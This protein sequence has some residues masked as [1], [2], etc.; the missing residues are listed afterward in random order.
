MRD[1]SLAIARW[2][3][4]FEVPMSE[5]RSMSLRDVM[6]MRTVITERDQDTKQGVR[7]KGGR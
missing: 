6:A 2:A 7:R 3:V 5:V 1:R 4:S